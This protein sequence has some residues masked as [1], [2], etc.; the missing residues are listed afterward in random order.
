MESLPDEL[1]VLIL[2]EYL[3]PS[4]VVTCRLV[5]KRFLFLVDNC[6]NYKEL[7][8]FCQHSDVSVQAYGDNMNAL[9]RP[10]RKM[11]RL[12]SDRY[13]RGRI[14]PEAPFRIPFCN[15]K[16]LGLDLSFYLTKF[17]MNALNELATVEKLACFQATISKEPS[18][19]LVLRMPNLKVLSFHQL[20]CFTIG[21]PNERFKLIVDSKIEQLFYP[22]LPDQIQLNHPECISFLQ[23]HHVTAEFLS[24]K[25]L[26]NL[27]C[28]IISE[29]MLPNL[30]ESFKHLEKIFVNYGRCFAI[31]ND[32]IF[33]CLMNQRAL[34]GRS[35]VKIYF[36]AILLTKPFEE[37]PF[38]C[39]FRHFKG[40]D[41][42][43]EESMHFAHY[44]HLEDRLMHRTHINYWSFVSALNDQMLCLQSNRVAFNEHGFPVDF[45]EKF[46]NIRELEVYERDNE[47]TNNEARFA[48]FLSQCKSLRTIF[49]LIS[50]SQFIIDRVSECSS[51]QR[52]LFTGIALKGDDL[53]YWPLLRL[54]NLWQLEVRTNINQTRMLVVAML[55]ELRYLMKIRVLN[56]EGSF[57][58]KKSSGL[59][60]LEKYL[61]NL[62][63]FKE[64]DKQDLTH[65][66]L[67][68]LLSQIE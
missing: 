60:R 68:E 4:E 66:A 35:N 11:I 42:L 56:P 64:M 53:D 9:E 50:P 20:S 38:E 54:K 67:L 55:K 1:I 29:Q 33:N 14:F 30:L 62:I 13:G 65:E 49:V 19:Q 8:I 7:T 45:F 26:R 57:D 40:K 15:L 18:E 58:I 27:R 52:L 59:Y 16:F 22:F 23:T 48:W 47:I 44:Q 39:N 3:Y 21:R 51:L 6:V 32:L 41:L 28:K 46:Q 63:M 25:N 61:R 37:Y 24:L 43:N 5:S 10:T 12:Q 34:L 36:L 31:D 17:V 2:M